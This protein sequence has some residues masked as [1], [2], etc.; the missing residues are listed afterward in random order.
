MSLGVTGQKGIMRL[1]GVWP[2]DAALIAAGLELELGKVRLTLLE[3]R[4][5]AA[6]EIGHR[7]GFRGVEDI[8]RVIMHIDQPTSTP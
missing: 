2:T 4:V 7:V 3:L 5:V 8:R 6:G 1:G